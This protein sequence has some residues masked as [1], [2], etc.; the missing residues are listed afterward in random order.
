MV[1]AVVAVRG[2][3]DVDG[4]VVEGEGGSL[5][6]PEGVVKDASADVAVANTRNG[7]ARDVSVNAVLKAGVSD[8][9]GTAELVGA[10][11]DVESVQ[12]LDKV[13]APPRISLVRATR[14]MVLWR[15]R[16]LACLGCPLR[17]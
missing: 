3:C 15:G 13:E 1:G 16:S 8:D 12:G 7:W 17:G 10:G 4:V 9:L 6:L 5:V 2:G 14:Y 11:A